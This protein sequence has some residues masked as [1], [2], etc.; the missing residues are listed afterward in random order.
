MATERARRSPRW[1][2][3]TPLDTLKLN[4]NVP[5]RAQNLLEL[6]ANEMATEPCQADAALVAFHANTLKHLAVLKAK[7]GPRYDAIQL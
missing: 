2:P 3:S 6:V 4:P 5:Q 7:G 1:W